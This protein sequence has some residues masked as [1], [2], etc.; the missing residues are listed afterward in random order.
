MTGGLTVSELLARNLSVQW[1]E[2]IAI[3][4]GVVACLLAQQGSNPLALPELHQIDLRDDGTVV[5][6]GEIEVA[7]PVRRLGQLL[8]ATLTDTDVPVQLRLIVSQA[9]APSASYPSVAAFDQALA[10]FE[11]PD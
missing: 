5:I 1:L 3:V 10:Y 2:G 6:T 8:Q 9:T 11:R 4:R 7:E